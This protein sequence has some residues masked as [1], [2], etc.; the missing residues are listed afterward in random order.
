LYIFLVYLLWID[1]ADNN[2]EWLEIDNVHNNNVAL[3]HPLEHKQFKTD[4]MHIIY[5]MEIVIKMFGVTVSGTLFFYLRKMLTD[6]SEN[7]GRR[8][9]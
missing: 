1:E 4:A 7:V 3:K 5:E 2:D 9:F 6:L 8:L